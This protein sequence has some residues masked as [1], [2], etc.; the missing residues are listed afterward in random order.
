[1][2]TRCIHLAVVAAAAMTLLAGAVPAHAAADLE[3]VA[4]T[5]Q[6]TPRVGTCNTLSMTVKNNGDAFT[7]NATLDIRVI[8]FPAGSPFQSRVEKDLFISPMQG[9]AQ[10]TF[11][12]SNVEFKAPGAAT[13][14]AVV[15]STNETSE[16][17]ENNNSQTLS[18][19]VSGACNQPPPT[20]GP[21]TGPGC[22]LSLVFTAPSGNTVAAPPAFTLRAKNEGSGTCP[23]TKLRLYRY[24]GSRPGG[25]GSAVGGTRNIWAIPS[26]SPGQTAEN[27]FTDKVSKGVYTYSPKFLGAWNDDNN[28]NHQTAK[29]VT[30]Q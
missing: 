27:T 7:G 21:S 2:K 8:T 9:G 16:S 4:M 6:G 13:I 26:L 1:M 18:T 17:N 14:Q 29:T 19:T 3:I 12:I 25:Y 28:G 30:V 10:V 11:P 20:P 23:A 15:D 5:V 22:D 24:N